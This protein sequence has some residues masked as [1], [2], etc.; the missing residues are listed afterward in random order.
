MKKLVK[1]YGNSFT[2]TFNYEDRKI[3]DIEEGDYIEMDDIVVIKKGKE[4]K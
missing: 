4:Q 2:I 3:Y 1:K